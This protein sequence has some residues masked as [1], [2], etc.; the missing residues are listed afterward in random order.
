VTKQQ[1]DGADIRTSFQQMDC[2]RVPERMGC[3]GLVD[4]GNQVRSSTGFFDGVGR[5]GITGYLALEQPLLGTC[6]PPVAA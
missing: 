6:G 1:L 3:D 4:S 5:H 2:E